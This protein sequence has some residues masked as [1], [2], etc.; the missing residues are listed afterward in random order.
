MV[1]KEKK[2][3]QNNCNVCF[4][5]KFTF[6]TL[7]HRSQL[8]QEL[9]SLVSQLFSGNRLDLSNKQ[10]INIR[11]SKIWQDASRAFSSSTFT[12]SL[13]IRVKFIGEM[14]VDGGGPCREFY[15][16]LVEAIC[17]TSGLL[18]GSAGRKI[19]SHNWAA[20]KARK[21][22][23]LG[24]MAGMSMVDGGPGLPVF[25]APVFHYIATD[26]IAAGRVED[27]PD[28]VVRHHLSLVSKCTFG[29]SGELCQSTEGIIKFRRITRY[30]L[31]PLITSTCLI[32]ILFKPM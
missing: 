25:A 26:S 29:H 8:Q 23:L 16:L 11:R 32:A 20:L 15:R 3:G 28:P 18:E 1:E 10:L 2:Q 14:G 17:T 6:V 7:N 19:P 21:F 24:L 13:G 5:N 12:C 4:I 22:V 31:C 27:V 9:H 30:G